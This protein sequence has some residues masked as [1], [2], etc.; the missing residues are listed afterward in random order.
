MNLSDFS[1]R[2]GSAIRTV[3]IVLFLT[4]LLIFAADKSKAKA[5]V[6]PFRFD[7]Y[8]G[9]T[10]MNTGHAESVI[11]TRHANA[12]MVGETARQNPGKWFRFIPF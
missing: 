10:V 4:I 11:M 12:P 6:S 1:K 5:K 7:R 9:I 2:H 8:S 3:S